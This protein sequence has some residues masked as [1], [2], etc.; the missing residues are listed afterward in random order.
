MRQILQETRRRA[1]EKTRRRM[2]DRTPNRIHRRHH[3]G[4]GSGEFQKLTPPICR[5]GLSAY[6]S[7]GDQLTA[8]PAYRG[9][10]DA[11]HR[12]E[13][14]DAKYARAAQRVDDGK[15]ARFEANA[16]CVVKSLYLSIQHFGDTAKPRSERCSPHIFY[17]VTHDA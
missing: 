16:M 11:E 17:K 13:L 9:M 7:G 14:T 3:A 8:H 2:T 10:R 1:Q 6:Q 15:P 12:R 4:V 5:I